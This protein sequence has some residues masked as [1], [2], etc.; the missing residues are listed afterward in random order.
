MEQCENDEEI[1]EGLVQSLHLARERLSA[2]HGDGIS[3]RAQGSKNEWPH[4]NWSV[5]LTAGTRSEFA[6]RDPLSKNLFSF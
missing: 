2:I 4:A 5:V 3:L 6:E 1:G